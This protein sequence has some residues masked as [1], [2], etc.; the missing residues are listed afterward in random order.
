[1]KSLWIVTLV[2]ITL[3]FVSNGFAQ[4]FSQ[5]H[6]PEGAKAKIGKGGVE[7]FAYF[8]DGARLACASGT[9]IWMY[10]AHTGEQISLL[11]AEANLTCIALSPDGRTV[12][13]GG[14]YDH[15]V[16][17]WDA[18]TG[19]L[20]DTLGD[21]NDYV[22]R[23]AYSRDGRTIATISSSGSDDDLVRLWD[24]TTGQ[25]KVSFT[26]PEFPM[27]MRFSPDG[28]TVAVASWKRVNLWD[29]NTGN[30]KVTLGNELSD[31]AYSP[32]GQTLALAESEQISLW[33]ANTGHRKK[34]K[35]KQRS[36][37]RYAG[38]V[39]YSPDGQTLASSG[40]DI[41]E[42][43]LWEAATGRLKTTPSVKL[44]HGFHWMMYSPDGQTLALAALSGQMSLC[45]V[46]T[47]Q[48]IGTL[49]GHFSDI[50][51][52]V[53]SP[54]GRTLAV[55]DESA[56]NL[57]DVNTGRRKAT[58]DVHMGKST[59][60][61]R[62]LAYSPDGQ[63]LASAAGRFINLWDADT[64]DL[65]TALEGHVSSVW[66]LTYSPDG[67]TLASASYDGTIRLW[68]I[69]TGQSKAVLQEHAEGDTARYDRDWFTP[70]GSL[71]YSPDGQTLASAAGKFINLWDVNTKTHKA[72]LRGEDGRIGDV[73]Y[74]P[75]GQTLANT[76][77]FAIN[78][79][80]ATTGDLK[81]TLK[82]VCP[83][84]RLAYSPDGSVL[85][86]GG[87]DGTVKLWN[88]ATWKQ[89]ATFHGDQSLIWGITYS[90][91]SST[92]ASGDWQGI[93]IL[94]DLT[95]FIP[96]RTQ[97]K[98]TIQEPPTDTGIKK[99]EREMVRLIYFRPN[100][101][102]HREDIDTELDTV[103]KSTQYFY[104]EQMQG[105]GGRKTF[106][107]ET[108]DTGYARVH[109]VTGKFTDTYYH[110]D[111]YDKVVKEVSEKFDTSSNVYLI[112]VDVS[113]E[114]INHEGTCGMGGGGWV[115]SD[116]ELW[117]RNFGGVAV[118]PAS[119]I[120]VNP[121][122]TAHEL[123]HAF[124]LGHDFRDDA[125]L[126]AY[127]TQERL[128]P[129]AAEWL[130][131]HR[132]FNPD[133]TFF[134]TVATVEMRTRRAAGP[135]TLH[136]Q[137]ELTDA[138]GLH[139]AQVLVPAVPTD[140]APGLKLHSCESLN[141]KHQ[142]VEFAMTDLTVAS[143]SEVTLQVIDGRGNIIK[144]TFRV[145]TD[146]IAKVPD[147]SVGED[148]ATVSLPASIPPAAIGDRLT[149]PVTIDG[150]VDVA[151]YQMD[152][153]FDVSA[154]RY[155]SSENA[156]Y[157]PVGAFVVP[158]SVSGNRV[159]LA[160]TSLSGSSDGN[161]T[162]A[163]FTFEV[164]AAN[165]ALPRLSAAKLTDSNADFLE[166]RIENT[167]EVEPVRLAGDVNE[168][169]IV[170]LEDMDAAA[171]RLGQTGENTADMNNNGIVDAADLLLIAA[172]IEQA[173]AAP[174]LHSE[175]LAHLFTAAEVRQWL[176]L[177]RQQG[178]TGPMYGRGFLLLTQLLAVLTPTETAV[179]PNYPNP[180]NPETWI[181]YQL[182]SPADV[183][184]HIYAINGSL[185]RTL[186]VG[187]QAAGIYQSR[188]RAAYWD[189]KNEFGEPV[190]SGVYF[191]TL[192]AGDFTATR[193][194]LIRK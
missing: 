59:Y 104:A 65:K 155:I 3:T 67:Q 18:N 170:N 64:G 120:C 35:I 33:N 100:D 17:L 113:S 151:G 152:I 49:E 183:T 139:Q 74:S 4:V 137:F 50:V 184:V 144:Q 1:M 30:L 40:S 84:Y 14:R 118:I 23:I 156:D 135:G 90:P 48:L 98:I 161:G 166:V 24:T 126:M 101:R 167:E 138:D 142:S 131:A 180:F 51:D 181:P 182:S 153:E 141:G 162:L 15:T 116:N 78:L 45:E 94:W 193:K 168:D 115:S 140:P 97:P 129:C 76:N 47:G 20:K 157:L 77:G 175:T 31:F 179:L 53:Y 188:S 150:G 13:G 164:I 58:L 136:L 107:F 143:D 80:D 38:S 169:G 9:G 68:D 92:L 191:Y 171:D 62:G 124:G 72:T 82:S 185:A 25:L 12:A 70:N 79:R 66:A 176:Q 128:S 158:A 146:S 56:V 186:V 11:V 52:V 178:L 112:A 177:A 86:G 127:G 42:V 61:P 54:D 88:T 190:A 71:A 91:D 75:D 121:S 39:A 32:D 95:P 145:E 187:H 46:V 36:A 99:Y 83:L 55:A 173:N 119:G 149:L 5:K 108:E 111:T 7:S 114:F 6:L 125:Y 130:D 109:Q 44:T 147:E 192:T 57:W 103:I 2:F 172:A 60:E 19:N 134:N 189:G 96:Q 110:Q 85:A 10:N 63:T 81:G 123:G 37:N 102:P 16:K 148:V 117:Q 165:P 69:T 87:L 27:K 122:V 26:I 159:T 160:A 28:R 174:S 154:L 8:P 133:P 132:F 34:V 21:E 29:A 194:M 106:A 22:L 89:E 41:G 93:A 43:K 163:T 105:Y 73:T